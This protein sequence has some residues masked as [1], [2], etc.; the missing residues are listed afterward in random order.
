MKRLIPSLAF[1]LVLLLLPG[2]AWAQQGTVTGTVTEAETD[3]PLPGATIQVVDQEGTGAATDSEGQYRITGVPAGDQTIRVTF[4]GYQSVERTVNVPAGGTVRANFELRTEE[5]ALDEVVVTGIASETSRA[6][7]EVSVGRVDAGELQVSNSYSG[8]SELLGAKVSG[9]DIRRSSGNV[10]GGFR[11]NIRSGGG[12]G[13]GGQPAIYIDGVRVDNEEVDGFGVGGQGISAL[14]QLNPQDIQDIEFLKGPAAAALYGTSGSNGVVLITTRSGQ[15]GTP[16]SVRYKGVLGLN[17]QQQDYTYGE[18]GT[19]ELANDLR[20]DGN[21]QEHN[22]SVSGGT[23]LVSYYANLTTRSEDGTLRNNSLDRNSFR[24][25]FEAFPTD[26]LTLTAKTGYTTSSIARPQNDNNIYGYVGNST[27]ARVRYAF[28]DSQAVESAENVLENN[29]F[30]G[31][32][33]ASWTPID[34]LQ[35]NATAGYQSNEGRN[36]DTFPADVS[37][38]TINNGARGIFQRRNEQFTYDFSARYNYSLIEGLNATSTVGGQALDRTERTFFIEKQNFPTALV[39]NVGAGSQFIQGDEAFLDTREAGIFASQQLNYDNTYFLTLGLRRDYSTQVG[40]NAPNIFYPKVSGALRLDQFDF[41]PAAFDLLKIRGAYGETGQLPGRLDGLARLWAAQPSGYGTGAALDAIGNPGIEPE[42]VREFTVG[43]DADLFGRSSLSATYFYNKAEGSIISFQEAPSTGLVASAR[44]FN[45]GEKKG[46]GVELDLSVTPIQRD[47]I[48]VTADVLYS[49]NTNT[50]ESLGGAQPIF[51]GF[52]RNVTKVG[53]PQNAFYMFTSDVQYLDESGNPLTG[54][55]DPSAVADY[56]VV[57]GNT[58]ESGQPAREFLGT[59]EPNHSASVSLNVRL[60][61]NLQLYGLLDITRGLKVYDGNRAF[62]SGL[63]SAISANKPLNIARYVLSD[64]ASPFEGLS[65]EE[66][67]DSNLPYLTNFEPNSATPGTQEY[68]RQA[69]IF[70]NN[71]TSV[72]G[73]ATEGNFVSE[74]DY[75]KLR[76]VSVSYNFSDLVNRLSP[77]S[78]IENMTLSL[79]AR[80]IFTITDYTGFDPEVN[81]NGG[82]GDIQGQDFL[83]LPQPQ[84]LT[85]S[86]NVRF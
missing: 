53:L 31:S 32:V 80:N 60:F 84:T 51:G 22:L 5:Q 39:E 72:A 71:Q 68:V 49:Y 20:R 30:T 78:A 61:D 4:V 54:N 28:A 21:I 57:P 13:G 59:P 74:G 17:Q 62:T 50:V 67:R 15:A 45:V 19:P 42:T 41:V 9:V 8:I 83:T 82:E 25:N 35:L 65:D 56:E 6:R 36:D 46:Q 12:I 16:V 63:S 43:F 2:L 24:A 81:F 37:Y 52:S 64:Q 10:G 23:E 55:F 26:D 34:G 33:Q 76:E 18:S 73:T 66:L 40:E 86:I 7:A 48:S 70:A 85:A 58:N 27:I 14:S 38:P 79:S 11:F 3:A 29:S 69:R 44:P 77:T 75:I 1:G 47:I